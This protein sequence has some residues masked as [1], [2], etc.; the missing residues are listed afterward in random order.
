M[1][2]TV[3]V[4]SECQPAREQHETNTG[5]ATGN[6]A[7]T[8][9]AVARKR[10][11]VVSRHREASPVLN[12]GMQDHCAS[13]SSTIDTERESFTTDQCASSSSTI[14]TEQAS[15]TAPVEEVLMEAHEAGILSLVYLKKQ[16]RHLKLREADIAD[17]EQEA[18]E[19][20][21]TVKDGEF[22]EALES[23]KAKP[24]LINLRPDVQQHGLIHQAV[25]WNNRDV[26]EDLLKLK[27]NPRAGTKDGKNALAVAKDRGHAELYALL[28]PRPREATAGR[29]KC[30]HPEVRRRCED[31]DAG[32]SLRSFNASFA[33]A[34]CMAPLI[35]DRHSAQDL[36]TAALKE[37]AAGLRAEAIA[38]GMPTQVV[39][40]LLGKEVDFCDR[41]EN[42]DEDD[43]AATLVFVYTLQ[44]FVYREVNKAARLR[45]EERLN[46]AP[47]M[48]GLHDALLSGENLQ[49]YRGAVYRVMRL[50]DE[51]I[52]QYKVSLVDHRANL[53]SWEG[54]TSATTAAH[55]AYVN[56]EASGANVLVIIEAPFEN[57]GNTG[58]DSMNPVLVSSFSEYP[59]EDEVI[60]PLGQQFRKLG[61]SRE[62]SGDIWSELGVCEGADEMSEV[63]VIRLRPE[64]GFYDFAEDLCR[65]GG[66]IAEA[67]PILQARLKW[68]QDRKSP[69]EARCHKQL[70]SAYI[71]DVK[72]DLAMHHYQISLD[73]FTQHGNP[74]D[75][76]TLKTCIAHAQELQVDYDGALATHKEVL[77][78]HAEFN[79]DDAQRAIGRVY[80]GMGMIYT[81]K[82][83]GHWDDALEHFTKAH[84]ILLEYVGTPSIE[85]ATAINCTG[86]VYHR[87]KKISNA[88]E[89]FKVALRMREQLLGKN[90]PDVALALMNMGA[91]YRDQGNLAKSV[92]TFEKAYE[93]YK[94]CF[95][96]ETMTVANVYMQ[97]LPIYVEQGEKALLRQ[98]AAESHH[99]YLTSLGKSHPNT[100]VAK[101]WVDYCGA[102]S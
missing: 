23:V 42:S 56:F 4:D 60:F 97:L 68:E 77:K 95:G 16:R 78:M 43:A 66:S 74:R 82:G 93:I 35:G 98:R 19:L 57:G 61:F 40:D 12:S 24:Y 15:S 7:E 67:L 72:Y 80:L 41:I 79:D 101:M 3:L 52:E 71:H 48:R 26:L 63:A 27:A 64:D 38:L 75:V 37:I 1:M 54:F 90:H 8:S 20:L 55:T 29:E 10:L 69:W 96:P 85:V 59:D 92:E 44:S 65:D 50:P 81:K 33:R 86:E 83:E 91:C 94:V 45:Q 84:E 73:M 47:F 39:S 30:D 76:A 62:R 18:Q 53:F 87:Q 13:S 31:D 6:A 88:M 49:R 9:D 34:V 28:R 32:G 21:D 5:A 70:A 2:C 25:W 36:D 51:I 22:S 89:N 11:G 100:K 46:L 58:G 17:L 99:I 102:K 14:D